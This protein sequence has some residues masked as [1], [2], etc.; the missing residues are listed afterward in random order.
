MRPLTRIY[1]TPG[2]TDEVIHL[3]LALGLSHGEMAHEDSEFIERREIRLQEALRMVRD[4][5]I[6]DSKTISTILFAASF[7]PEFEGLAASGPRDV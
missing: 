1:T 5:R 2:F 7:E 6:T 4:G 3:Y